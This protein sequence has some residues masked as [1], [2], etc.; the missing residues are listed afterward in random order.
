M[1]EGSLVAGRLALGD[2]LLSIN[3]YELWGH[4]LAIE[5]LKRATGTVT[6]R[7]RRKGASADAEVNA[8]ASQSMQRQ[9]EERVERLVDSLFAA[10]VE[11]DGSRSEK[12]VGA[13]NVAMLLGEKPEDPTEVSE[14]EAAEA[15]AQAAA[16]AESVAQ[17]P[18]L[19]AIQFQ[20]WE[21]GDSVPPAIRFCSEGNVLTKTVSFSYDST[22]SLRTQK[23]GLGQEYATSRCPSFRFIIKECDPAS[24]DGIAVGMAGAGLDG[25]NCWAFNPGCDYKVLA[26]KKTSTRAKWFNDTSMGDATFP[27]AAVKDLNMYSTCSTLAAYKK[28]SRPKWK[29]LNKWGTHKWRGCAIDVRVRE[30]GLAFRFVP[31]SGEPWEWLEVSIPALPTHIRPWVML[32]YRNESVALEYL[33]I[34]KEGAQSS[35]E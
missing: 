18:P 8:P 26:T 6:L 1:D 9:P 15:A 21:V 25:S 13:I 35:L 12:C 14:Q 3:G 34:S 23:T 10:P 7:V 28:S 30:K 4:K 11:A 16:E 17:Q 32:S 33:D 31:P 2:V 19:P 22:F 24:R 20:F 29:P 5:A 27:N